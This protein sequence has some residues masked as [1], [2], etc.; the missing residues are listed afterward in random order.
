MI[1]IIA[2]PNGIMINIIGRK[3]ITEKFKDPVEPAIKSIF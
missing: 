2:D 1:A 3:T